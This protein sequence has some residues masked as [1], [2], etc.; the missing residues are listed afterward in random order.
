M[1]GDRAFS[2][3]SWRP[4]QNLQIPYCGLGARTRPIANTFNSSDRD[5]CVGGRIY[6]A[7]GEARPSG[8]NGTSGPMNIDVIA[9]GKRGIGTEAPSNKLP[10]TRAKNCKGKPRQTG[11]GEP[12]NP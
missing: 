7:E 12:S 9:R 4:R 2:R 1:C 6:N 5:T 10:K 3:T 8:E 11:N